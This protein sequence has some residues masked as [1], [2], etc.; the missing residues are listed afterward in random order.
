M[1]NEKCISL[2][3]S[4]FLGGI[5]ME[6]IDSI[7]RLESWL[8]IHSNCSVEI[9]SR[10]LKTKQNPTKAKANGHFI[11]DTQDDVAD[12]IIAR[13]THKNGS[14]KSITVNTAGMFSF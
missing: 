11:E 13:A 4:R 3:I 12:Y 14:V 1:Y 5:E 10:K 9:L 7:C 8:K 2:D 6:H